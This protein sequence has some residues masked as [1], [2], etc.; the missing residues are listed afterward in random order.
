MKYKNETIIKQS[1]V[2]ESCFIDSFSVIENSKINRDCKIFKMARVKNS[3]LSKNC[4]VGDSSRVDESNLEQNIRIDRLNHIANSKCGRFSY[5]GQSTVIMFAEVKAFSSI[6][7]NVTIGPANH[8]YHNVTQHSFLYNNSDEIRKINEIAYDRFEKPCVIGND[9]WI[10][11]NS[12]ILRNVEIGDGAVIGANALVNKDVPPYAI[13]G[14]VPARVIKYR[15]DKEIIDLL[16]KIKW[17]EWD[18]EKIKDNYSFFSN[19]PERAKL[20][21]ILNESEGNK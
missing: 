5:T 3:N 17:W 8:N 2:H 13:V 15:F 12:T 20:V 19:K 6:S 16:L 1:D 14:G 10:G 11:C 21:E 9:V 18:L 7:W 4:I